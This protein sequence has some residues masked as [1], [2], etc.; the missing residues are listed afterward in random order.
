M[1]ATR[2]LPRRADRAWRDLA[3]SD[4]GLIYVVLAL[5][6][7][8]SWTLILA[9]GGQVNLTGA[10]VAGGGEAVPSACP[11]QAATDCPR[12]AVSTRMNARADFR[13]DPECVLPWR[14]REREGVV[15]RQ[16]RPMRT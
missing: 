11:E 4:T 3:T 12:T 15:G 1:I 10:T 8:V 14:R 9:T 5:V 16:P 13:F 7:L 2:A 6:A